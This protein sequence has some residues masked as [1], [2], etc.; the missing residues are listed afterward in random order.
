[1]DL[2]KDPI[3][4]KFLR[5]GAVMMAQTG[6]EWWDTKR[7]LEEI[8]FPRLAEKRIRT[9]QVARRGLLKSDGVIVLDDTDQP[10]V[11][12]TRTTKA[13]PY[14]TLGREMLTGGTIPQVAGPHVC[15]QR[16][17]GVPL[18]E[19]RETLVTKGGRYLHLI[20]FEVSEAS[21]I[22]KDKK[23]D[24]DTRCGWYPL[25]EKGKDRAAC[26]ASI[27]A[28]TGR[29][30]KKSACTFCP[31]A[32]N[33]RKGQATTLDRFEEWPDEAALPL[34]MEEVAIRLNPTQGLAGMNRK[35]RLGIRLRDLMAARP[36]LAPALAAHEARMDQSTWALYQVQRIRSGSN[37][38]RILA[39]R[40]GTRTE[41]E[42]AVRRVGARAETET[43]AGITRAWWTRRD[44]TEEFYVAAP[45]V[46]REKAR[47][48][49]KERWHKTTT[50]QAA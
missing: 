10:S 34:M 2:L 8:L 44:D 30:W 22:T 38:R 25:A 36:K 45:F 24:T 43:L 28:E 12:Y 47:P 3:A 18:D 21:R 32:I 48:G 1:M 19:T 31:F 14:Y 13:K 29:D 16:S 33:G 26:L 15:S 20:G 46:V 6:H 7:D 4:L 40:T 41:M 17:K 50:S 49:F 5:R 42:A 11:C 37:A 27:K 35:T 39:T 9:I 23:E